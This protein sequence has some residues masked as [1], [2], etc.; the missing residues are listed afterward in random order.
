[1]PQ[2]QGQIKAPQFQTL[3]LIARKPGKIIAA[4]RSWGNATGIVDSDP[5]DLNAAPAWVLKA[6]AQV[7]RVYM[8]SKRMFDSG[9]IDLELLGELIGRLR[10]YEK[11]LAGEI[12][13]GPEIKAEV[14]RIKKQ[15]ASPLHL[16]ERAAQEKRQMQAFQAT[17]EP[18]NQAIPNLVGATL[19]S[20]HD[21]ALKFQKGL[22]RGMNL[23][24]DELIVERIYQRHTRTF[25]VLALYWRTFSKCRS[26][27]EIHGILCKAVGEKRIGSFKT[28]EERV[29]KKIGLKVR[30]RGRP[31]KE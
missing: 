28:F 11:L 1:M 30:G 7:A 24:A 26:L 29:A 21:D 19:H 5:L 17:V 16:P 27:R 12:Q 8:P 10:A 9:E 14:E 4:I 2:P 20:S 22:S 18:T 25:L 13:V 3:K 6:W 15:E 23:S 31:P